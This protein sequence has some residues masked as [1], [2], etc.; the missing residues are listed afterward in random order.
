[1]EGRIMRLETQ[2]SDVQGKLAR[3]EAVLDKTS[4][5]IGK[6]ETGFA[7][8]TERVAHLPS[9]GFIVTSTLSALGF[10][11]AMTVFAEKIRAALGV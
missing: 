9:K 7:T 5:R 4:D 3:I 11:A 8:L 2:M 6:L 10:I 1:M